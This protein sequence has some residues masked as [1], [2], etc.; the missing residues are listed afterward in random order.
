MKKTT[1]STGTS[2]VHVNDVGN[3]YLHR[4]HELGITKFEDGNVGRAV[5]FDQH[6]IDMLYKHDFLDDQQHAACDRYL[7]TVI[8]GL[9]MTNPP[10]GERLSTGK[11]YIA[12]APRCLILIKVQ[13]HLRINCGIDEE[14]RF[15]VLMTNAPRKINE[16]DVRI[17]RDCAEA[18]L[19]YY[20]FSEDSPTSQF[21]QAL[22]DQ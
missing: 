12:P 14:N 22:T 13:R 5:V 17:I 4:R 9:H 15:W 16:K 11:Y 20:S 1:T 2:E 7:G 21:R 10:F 19:K 18:L 6:I 3:P 8:K